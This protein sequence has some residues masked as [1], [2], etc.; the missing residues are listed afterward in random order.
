MAN[1]KILVPAPHR[2]PRRGGIKTVTGEFTHLERLGAAEQIEYI[3]DG[4][5]WPSLAPGLC[6]GADPGGNKTFGG[7]DIENGVGGIF[8][9]YVG[10]ECFLG[11]GNDAEFTQRAERQLVYGEAHEVEAALVAWAG[12]GTAAGSGAGIGAAIAAAEEWADQYY[13]GAPVILMSR[14]NASLGKSDGALE[15]DGLGAV[16][17]VNGTPVVATWLMPDDKIYVIGWPTVY[18][19]DIASAAGHDLTHNRE[20]ALAERIYA[21]A[22]DCLFRAVVTVTAPVGD[23]PDVPIGLELTIGTE[24]SSPIPDG[25]DTTITVHTNI[26]PSGGEVNLFYRINGGAWVDNGEMVEVDPLTYVETVDGTLS[27]AGDVVELYGKSGSV[28]SPT[29]VINVT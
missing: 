21:M 26:A 4:C 29:I 27:S 15:G 28:V 13:I 6:W 22:V 2:E 20:M 8:A 9:Q 1:P 23:D 14:R 12:A 19:S 7:F 5:V 24:P 11:A 18:A 3:S 16:W 10:V 25:T 17:T